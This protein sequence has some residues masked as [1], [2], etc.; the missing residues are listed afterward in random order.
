MEIEEFLDIWDSAKSLALLRN[1][2]ARFILEFLLGIFSQEVAKVPYQKL[3][4]RLS[5]FLEK[6]NIDDTEQIKETYDEKAKRLIANWTT[7]GFLTNYR[8]SD[9]EIYYELTSHSSKTIAYVESLKEEEYIGTESKF[10]SIFS[11]LKELVENSSEDVEKR[12]EMLLSRKDEI[13][14]QIQKLEMGENVVF[15]DYQIESR[16]K[17]INQ[18]SKELLTDFKDVD[19]KFQNIIREMQSKQRGSHTI[20]GD[21]LNFFFDA[22]DNLK[23]SPQGKS[24]YAFWEFLSSGTLQNQWDKIMDELYR[25]LNSKHIAADNF[26]YNMKDYLYDSGKRVVET[27]NKMAEK[28]SHII[29]DKE[30]STFDAINQITKDIQTSINTIL[31]KKAKFDPNISLIIE[32][33]TPQIKLPLE[34][35]LTMNKKQD[36]EYNDKPRIFDDKIENSSEI[37]KVFQRTYIDRD[38]LERNICAL[39]QSKSQITVADI[40]EAHPLE[41][42]LEELIAYIGIISSKFSDKHLVSDSRSESI[43]FDIELGKQITIPQIIVTQ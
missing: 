15:E 30:G 1:K 29:R 20:K 35:T 16:F 9:G 3:L 4:D 19:S 23:Q 25:I 31:Q 41:K 26:L 33:N 11:Q 14:Q 28:L 40:V 38:K 24:F 13:E 34:R 10:K 8:D 37:H 42:G 32:E 6:H 27:N 36:F 43:I 21:I 39:L 18:Q 2:N 17:D 22:L 12:K 7:S 5:V